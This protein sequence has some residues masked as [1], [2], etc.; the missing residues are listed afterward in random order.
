MKQLKRMCL[1]LLWTTIGL[2]AQAQDQMEIVYQDGSAAE[3]I[4][5]SD[6][7][8]MTF[9]DADILVH[10]L[11]TGS[12]RTIN[13]SAVRAIKFKN[14]ATAIQTVAAD[15]PV[16]EAQAD[17]YDLQGRRLLTGISADRSQLRTRLSVLPRGVYIVKSTHKTFKIS[18]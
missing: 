12:A 7:L 17:V 8:K 15:T 13:M 18:K 3:T 16:A 11:S 2:A 6:V 1:L 9:A 5:L 14:A 4:Q 10:S